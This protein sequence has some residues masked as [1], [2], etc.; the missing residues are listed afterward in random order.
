MCEKQCRDENGFKCHRMSEVH[1]RQMQLFAQRPDKF[2]DDFSKEFEREFMRLISTRYARTRVLANSVYCEVI[3]DKQHIHMNSTI[4]V[5]LS[6]FVQHLARTQQ[7]KIDK[8]PRGWYLE[9][10]DSDKIERERQAYSRRKAEMTSQVRDEKRIQEAV[11]AARSSGGYQ[12]P[13]Y[14]PLQRS[15]G[16]T[17]GFKVPLSTRT[18][19]KPPRSIL[20]EAEQRKGPVNILLEEARK[21]KNANVTKVVTETKR[22]KSALERVMEENEQRKMV[23]LNPHRDPSMSRF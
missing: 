5:T 15:E 16:E 8:T 4:W 22:K 23:T 7:C 12:K 21:R 19:T 17:I 11:E 3:A 6:E 14:T 20:S 2:M 13:E 10:I 18:N 1:Q 9:Y